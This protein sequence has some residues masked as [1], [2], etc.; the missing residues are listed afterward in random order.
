MRSPRLAEAIVAV[1]LLVAFVA[2][3]RFLIPVTAA[4]LVVGAVA[5]HL[6]R[7]AIIG[8]GAL[9]LA[10]VLMATGSEVAAWALVLA[11]AAAA[12]FGATTGAP[13]LA[14]ARR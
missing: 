11:V 3:L 8:A 7:Q 6:R 10:T 12:G 13:V 5:G 4:A 14:G 9:G 2:D 1:A